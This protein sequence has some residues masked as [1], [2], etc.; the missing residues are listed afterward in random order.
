MTAKAPPS[1][2]LNGAARTGDAAERPRRGGVLAGTVEYRCGP[3]ARDG[4]IFVDFIND[5]IKLFQVQIIFHGLL[6]LHNY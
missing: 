5:I 3:I 4:L 6:Y 1:E 2:P